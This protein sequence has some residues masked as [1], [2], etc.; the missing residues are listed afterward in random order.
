MSRFKLIGT[1]GIVSG[2]CL[3]AGPASAGFTLP[4]SDG[5]A[6]DPALTN[7][8]QR[9][10]DNPS[11]VHYDGAGG[12]LAWWDVAIP[13]FSTGTKNISISINSHRSDSECWLQVMRSDGTIAAYLH[14]TVGVVTGWVNFS[15]ISVASSQ[16]MVLQCTISSVSGDY[17]ALIK[18]F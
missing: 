7:H 3:L 8:F 16:S 12:P 10:W 18:G 9:D 6:D 4:A 15:S 13:I 14:K 11:R 1:L 2:A 5:F 17:F